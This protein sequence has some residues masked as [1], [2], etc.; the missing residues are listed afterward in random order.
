MARSGAISIGVAFATVAAPMVAGSKAAVAT[1][2]AANLGNAGPNVG[3]LACLVEAVAFTAAAAGKALSVATAAAV[4]GKA[5]APPAS[6]STL[7]V[8]R[9]SATVKV[10]AD[11][12]EAAKAAK[13]VGAARVVKAAKAVG[14]VAKAAVASVGEPLPA[15]YRLREVEIS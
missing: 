7:V 3:T 13:A 4:A 12:T 5:A 6:T 1:A 2:T 11:H 8:A 10:V 15:G 14:A 9:R